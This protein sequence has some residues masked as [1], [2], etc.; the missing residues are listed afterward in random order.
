VTS[1][2]S[3]A[4][5][6]SSDFSPAPFDLAM[7]TICQQLSID[8]AGHDAHNQIDGL[9]PPVSPPTLLSLSCSLV[10]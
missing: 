1:E 3:V 4:R 7:S 8:L 10:I 5:H 2:Q 9:P 6:A